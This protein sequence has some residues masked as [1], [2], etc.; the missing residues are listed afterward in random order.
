MEY[1]D[2]NWTNGIVSGFVKA[3]SVVAIYPGRVYLPYQLKA[4]HDQYFREKGS[5]GSSGTA[6]EYT[7]IFGTEAEPNMYKIQRYDGT[8]INAAKIQLQRNNLFAVAHKVNHPPAGAT[9]N[10]MNCAFDF[11]RID[12]STVLNVDREQLDTLQR[13][14]LWISKR[15]TRQDSKTMNKPFFTPRIAEFIPNAYWRKPNVL[16]SFMEEDVQVRSL[17]MVAVRDIQH[18]EEIFVNYRFNPELQN[19][20]EWYTPVDVEE[21]YQRWGVE[22]S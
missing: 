9:P 3:G 6:D 18:G 13:A 2:Y 1:H 15:L 12:D 21:D 17:V 19:L 5:A 14:F 4:I 10:V 20:P 7:K 16:H 8:V 22:R 11:P